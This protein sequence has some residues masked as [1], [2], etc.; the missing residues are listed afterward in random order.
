[1]TLEDMKKSCEV[2]ASLINVN[3]KGYQ[4]LTKD[5]LGNGYCDWDE[6]AAFATDEKE[7]AL[8]NSKRSQYWAAVMLRY[9]YKIFKW[10]P[11][12]RSL[13]LEPIEYFDW[14]NQSLNG[15]FYYRS[16]RPLRYDV[17]TKTWIENPQYKP[18]EE[19]C[20]DKSVNYFCSAQRGR[21]YQEV[22]KDKRKANT[23]AQSIDKTFDED[24]YSILDREGLSTEGRGY[25]GIK[26]LINLFLNE[27]KVIEAVILDTIAYG[28]SVKEQKKKFTY[29]YTENEEVK[30]DTG[31]R[32]SHEFNERK[33]VKQ[34]TEINEKYFTDYFN[35]EYKVKDYR[36]ILEKLKSLNN[37]KLHNEIQKTL[38]SIKQT[39]ELLQ[40]LS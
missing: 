35:K 31:Y 34:L 21:I 24:G 39:P 13:N 22:N 2:E 38:M 23:Q 19:N 9:W 20:F 7:K 14:L 12:C 16:W 28:D 29:N 15:A 36:S 27:N 6:K 3:G 32:Y 8:A 5:E 40:F 25:N 1:M 30:E 10:I 37:G 11:E 33:V 26:S 4:E 18:N 17:K